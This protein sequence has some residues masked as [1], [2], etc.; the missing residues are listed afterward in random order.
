[1]RPELK[2]SLQEEAAYQERSLGYIMEQAAIEY[3]QRRNALPPSIQLKPP[4][5]S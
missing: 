4:R 5:S 1:M 2:S 3:L